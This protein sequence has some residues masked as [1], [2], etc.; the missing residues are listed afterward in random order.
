M[1]L[2]CYCY[3]FPHCW[4][5]KLQK[6]KRRVFTKRIFW[7][8]KM[9][10]CCLF[11]DSKFGSF[12]M[13]AFIT[14]LLSLSVVT[15]MN[16]FHRNA[17]SVSWPRAIETLTVFWPPFRRMV[18]HPNTKCLKN[19]SNK[20]HNIYELQIKIKRLN[21]TAFLS[22]QQKKWMKKTERVREREG[23]LRK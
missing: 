11:C 7:P 23:C 16:R 9:N 3:L 12:Y 14:L 4:L 19:T 15:S 13:F 10:E 8:N 21:W 20:F 6:N 18:H 17:Y 1:Q 2:F 5:T 22:K